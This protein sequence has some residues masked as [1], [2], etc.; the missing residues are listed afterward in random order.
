L[1]AC[2][3]NPLTQSKPIFV[4]GFFG[5]FLVGCSFPAEMENMVVNQYSLVSAEVDTPF[6]NSLS[7]RQVEGGEGTVSVWGSGVRNSVFRDALRESLEQ[8]R[9]LASSSVEA[10]FDL[11][12]ILEKMKQPTTGLDLTV[13]SRVNYRVVERDTLINWFYEPVTVS[14]TATF[15]DS[16]LSVLRLRIANEGSIRENLM[17]FIS[18]LMAVKNSP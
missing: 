11:Y 8:S 15:S 9:L 10:K 5:L 14:Y 7:I 18:R 4:L 12:A 2:C 6:K 1:V 17:Q 3:G 13:T 16:P